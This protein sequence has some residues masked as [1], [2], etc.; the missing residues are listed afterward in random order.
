MDG[1]VPA[2][3]SVLADRNG[4]TDGNEKADG[5]GEMA[6]YVPFYDIN[7]LDTRMF[8]DYAPADGNVPADRN[9]PVGVKVP[10]DGNVPAD[11]NVSTEI[12]VWSSSILI[13]CYMF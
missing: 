13:K 7:V 11:G 8:V 10:S 1:Y 2:E 9:I 4:Q 5:N 12:F 6:S 3:N